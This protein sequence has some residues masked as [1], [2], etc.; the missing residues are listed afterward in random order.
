MLKER[1]TGL[2]FILEIAAIILAL[3]FLVPF[4][5]VLGNSFK[6]FADILQNTSSLPKSLDFT[7]Y[8]QAIEVMNFWKA[9]LNSLIV[10]VASNVVIV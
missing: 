10:T 2:T 9:L 7:N 3:I 5:Y 8:Q 1:Y 4:Y 6:S